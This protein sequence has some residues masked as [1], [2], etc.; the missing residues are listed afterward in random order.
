VVPVRWLSTRFADGTG[1]V[2]TL[3]R[4]LVGRDSGMANVALPHQINR[5]TSVRL[6]YHGQFGG[7][8]RTLGERAVQAG[9]FR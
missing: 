4:V 5:K 9:V 1:A 7:G 6:W 3:R 8:R 2:V